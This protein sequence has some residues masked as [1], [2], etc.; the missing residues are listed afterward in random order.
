M[1][2]SKRATS[3]I[4]YL[5]NAR[6]LQIFTLRNCIK[7][8]KRYTF[9]LT[10]R[11]AELAEKIDD[12]IRIAESILPTNLHEAQIR[13]D[14]FNYAYGLLNALDD[15][16]NLM[17]DIVKESPNFKTEFKW[18]PNAMLEWGRMI[19]LERELIKGVKKSDRKRF[20]DKFAVQQ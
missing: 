14:E 8:P 10:Q 4:Q 12:H 3:T 18:L 7:F 15:K 11:I 13:R 19:G 1:Y 16:L 20:D 2:K 17:Y 5:E 9:V 6:Q